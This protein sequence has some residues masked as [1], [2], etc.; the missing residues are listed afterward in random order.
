MKPYIALLRGINVSGQKKIIMNDLK[1]AFLDLGYIDVTTY[2]QSGNV[3]FQVEDGDTNEMLLKLQIE[4]QLKDVF[5]YDIPVTV[6][7]P[8]NLKHTASQN[9]FLSAKNTTIDMLYISFLSDEPTTEHIDL[10]QSY[11][12]EI[13][14][15]HFGE[16]VVYLLYRNGYGRA[17][18][19]NNFI[20][21]KLQVSATTRNWKTVNK[22]IELS[23]MVV[24]N[25]TP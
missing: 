24:D 8:D 12:N 20:E 11:Q 10:L 9:P 15:L 4:K 7:S 18:I 6:L 14:L 22:L 16:K 3:V 21:R 5:H 19:T 23:S 25:T 13:E 2:V 17:K 1:Q